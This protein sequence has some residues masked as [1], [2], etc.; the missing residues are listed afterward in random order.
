MLESTKLSKEIFW[1]PVAIAAGFI[2]T[3]ST[4]TVLFLKLALVFLGK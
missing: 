4:L 1:Y 2:G 3:V